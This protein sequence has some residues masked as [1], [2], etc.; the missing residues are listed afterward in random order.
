MAKQII[1]GEEA[2]RSLERGLKVRGFDEKRRGEGAAKQ[3][4]DSITFLRRRVGQADRPRRTAVAAVLSEKQLQ[5]P[6][7]CGTFVKKGCAV[8]CHLI[9]RPSPSNTR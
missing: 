9:H 4:A 3:A 8:G 5:N 1:F 6:T 7:V 2:R